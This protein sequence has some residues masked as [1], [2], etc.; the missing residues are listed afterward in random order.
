MTL[1]WGQ[2]KVNDF[3]YQTVCACVRACVRACV[4]VCVFSQI[5]DIKHRPKMALDNVMPLYTFTTYVKGIL[6]L[7]GGASKNKLKDTS[8]IFSMTNVTILG[9][10][11]THAQV[12]KMNSTH[13][14]TFGTFTFFKT[15]N[16]FTQSLA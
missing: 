6:S 15:S 4:C 13:A 9:V 2:S 11:R 10:F 5:K 7:G 3:L 16:A 8:F 14:L 12:L 1:G